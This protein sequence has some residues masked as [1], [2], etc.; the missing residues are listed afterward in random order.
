[1][2][3]LICDP[4]AP[5][6][7]QALQDAGIEVDN[8]PDITAEELLRDAALYDGM[9]VRSRTCLLYTSDAADDN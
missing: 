6:T 3:V 9:V 5:V 7:I 2:K 1:M 8:R 4:V